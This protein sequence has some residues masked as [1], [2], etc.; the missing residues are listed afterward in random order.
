MA[1]AEKWLTA[2]HKRPGFGLLSD[3]TFALCGNGCKMEGISSE[4]GFLAGRL[5]SDNLYWIYYNNHIAIEGKIDIAFTEDVAGRFLAY[6]WNVLILCTES[7]QVRF[8]VRIKE[9]LAALLPRRLKFGRCD[10]PVR[11][12]FFGNGTQ[13]LA[14]IFQSGSAEEPV[15]VVD[16]INDKTGLEHNHV[17]NH[18]IVG[19]IGV[20]GDVE[21]FLDDTPHVG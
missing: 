13:V 11:P 3:R 15:A 16:L 8:A 19:R 6:E 7:L 12:A 5:K 14:E 21:V 20:F 18:R 4:A 9:F 10:V 2:P 17:G 1:I